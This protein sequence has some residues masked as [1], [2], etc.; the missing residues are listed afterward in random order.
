M[1]IGFIIGVIVACMIGWFV[2]FVWSVKQIH[3]LNEN[4]TY[5]SDQFDN[6]WRQM[7]K[8]E[9]DIRRDVSDRCDEIA[10]N[11][12][13]PCDGNCGRPMAD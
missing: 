12:N 3:K 1:F 13:N 8:R 9:E 4:M 6:V 2:A 10:R 5:H 7:T 11:V